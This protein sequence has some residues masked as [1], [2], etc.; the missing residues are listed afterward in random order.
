RTVRA[1][2]WDSRASHT[3]IAAG[4]AAAS[5]SASGGQSAVETGPLIG[6]ILSGGFGLGGG[7]V[8]GVVGVVGGDHAAFARARH[9]R[10]ALVGL[11]GMIVGAVDAEG[12]ELGHVALGP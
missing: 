5:C 8:G 4:G 7:W 11:E 9:Q 1:P 12:G 10:P 2:T 3:S 6:H